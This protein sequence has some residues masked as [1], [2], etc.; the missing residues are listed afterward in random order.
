MLTYFIHRADKGLSA[1]RRAQLEWEKKLLA[2]RIAAQ[3]KH[4]EDA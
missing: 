1:T 3:K 2:A 4:A